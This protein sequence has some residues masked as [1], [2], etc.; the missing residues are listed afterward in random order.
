MA[1]VSVKETLDSLFLDPSS[2]GSFGGASRLLK[3]AK[4]HGIDEDQVLQYLQAIDAYTE[5][6]ARRKKFPRRRII[7]VDVGDQ[8]QV[9]LADMQKFS[10]F[11]DGYKYILTVI[12]CFSRFAWGVPVKSKKPAEIVDGLTK[13]YQES[14]PPLRCQSDKGKEFTA[15]VVRAFFKE[16]NV[17]FFTTTNDDVKCAMVERLNRTIKERLWLYMTYN[18]NFRYIDVLSS[19][20]DSYNASV[21]SSIGFAPKDVDAE[22]A[23]VIRTRML[24]ERDRESD[25]KFEVGDYTRLAKRKQTFEKGYETNFTEEI[26]K[27]VSRERHQHKNIYTVVDLDE[28]PVEGTFYEAEL[29]KVIL[30]DRPFHA[31][32]RV[33]R[34]RKYKGRTQYLVRWKGYGPAYDSWEYKDDVE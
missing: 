20:L 1:S 2:P 3:E 26:F 11:N 7:S 34:Q 27:V 19:I 18:N 17:T 4:K 30:T 16:S 9:D 32:S 28:K 22:A 10:T 13:I 29:S 12:D 23:M 8:H 6:K 5:H 25:F 33:L 14:P 31:I 15:K 21:H 24:Q